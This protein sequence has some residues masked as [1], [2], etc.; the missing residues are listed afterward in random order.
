MSYPPNYP[1]IYI[2][3]KWFLSSYR[4][5]SDG[6]SGIRLLEARLREKNFHL[7]EW[8]IAWI[9]TCAILR[10]AIDL[11]RVD[12]KSCINADIRREILEEWNSIK[13]DKY[14]HAIFWEF[15][16]KERASLCKKYFY[17]R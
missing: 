7:F 12:S 13:K 5:L 2:P 14:S 9:G 11:F 6:M 16:K 17:Y 3:I 1:P 4:A 10:T 8:K 15:L